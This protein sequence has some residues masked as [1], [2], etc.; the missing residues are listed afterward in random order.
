MSTPATYDPHL[1][2]RS[3]WVYVVVSALVI[4]GLV[5]L[6]WSPWTPTQPSKQPLVVYCAAG[7][8]KP[9]QAI[10]KQYEA[11]YGVPVQIEPAGSG[12]L[13]AKIRA[14]PDLGDL[15]LSAE[16]S[17]ID[18]LQADQPPRVREV[19]PVV[20]Q[21]PVLAVS[22]AGKGKIHSLDD[23]LAD[24]VTVALAN[25]EITAVGHLAKKQLSRS[26]HWQKLDAQRAQFA[27][28]V[29]T[30]GTVNEAAQAVQVGAVQAAII[31]D[32]TARQFD[33]TV[34]PVPELEGVESLI[35]IGVLSSA[36]HP[37]TALH[38]ARYLSARDKGA[39][40]FAKHHFEPLAGA[41]QWAERPKI[42]LMTGAMLRPSLEK[43]LKEFEAREGIELTWIFNG[44]GI[45]NTQILG[46]ARPDAYFACDISFLPP[47][48]DY[49][50]APR[51]L[52]ENDL[53][54]LVPKGQNRIKTLADLTQPALRVGLGHP[55][56]SALGAV[57]VRLLKANDQF[58]PLT[59]SGNVKVE[60]ATGD[61]LVNQ[62]VAGALDAAIVYRSN[63]RA[64]PE[65]LEKHVDLVEIT[66]PLAFA[67][68]PFAVGK[69]SLHAQLMGRL[70]ETIRGQISRERFKSI[71]FRWK[72][73]R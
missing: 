63:A 55:D 30:V 44:C 65:N 11:D 53:V 67:S 27:A 49:F 39:L 54:I 33:L 23:L 29:S 26:G 37:T 32:A 45:L 40:E 31:W 7:L 42:E 61:H 28:K 2:R 59:S 3:P 68:Q 43:T 12:Q 46:G 17:F 62:V 60:S 16:E 51:E 64:T 50:D 10:A 5:L 4:A 15:F 19:I 73:G 25:P 58:Q 71:G 57:T 24:D 66:A 69:N 9:V 72:D 36:R 48:Q 13:M 21:R 38:F 18:K 47:V 34:V 56:K 6:L 8:I 52:T 22:S 20:R 1:A 14:A 41:D 35:E 70:L